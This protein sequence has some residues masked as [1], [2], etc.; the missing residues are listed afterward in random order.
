MLRLLRGKLRVVLALVLG[1]PA[2]ATAGD[3]A[4]FQSPC[5][6]L[7]GS[8]AWML[9]DFCTAGATGS[10]PAQ[11]PDCHHNDDDS[12]F[13]L[14][15]F[16]FSLFGSDFGGA[17]IN[18]NG[19][20]T[21]GQLSSAFTSNGFPFNGPL[22]VAPFWA[23]VDTGDQADAGGAHDRLGHVYYKVVDGHTLAVLWDNVGY[24]DERGDKLNT[25]Q[26]LISD[27]SNPEMG[28]GNNVCFCYDDMQWT[29]GQASGSTNGFG[30][31][32]ATVGINRG[33]G[34]DFFQI[35]RFN[36][37]GTS[38][39]GPFGATDGVDFLDN[40][41][42]GAGP[43]YCFNASGENVAPVPVGFPSGDTV[44]I[45]CKVPFSLSLDF[46]SPE[47][48]QTTTVVIDDPD[49]A[50]AA[51]LAISN[52]PGETAEVQL[53]WVPDPLDKGTYVLTFTATDDA[54]DPGETVRTLTIVVDCPNQ[55]PVAACTAV[56]VSADRDTCTAAASID[57]GSFDPDLDPITLDQDPPP[58]YPLGDTS[59]TLIVSD[60]E[61]EDSCSATVTVEDVT[62]PVISGVTPS[63]AVLWPPNHKMHAVTLAVDVT[64]ACGAT[65]TCEIVDVT[66]NEPLN[67]RG[68][69]NT[70]ADW[71]ITG[72]LTANLRAERA[73]PL[74]GRV[75]T[76]SLSCVDQAGNATPA[77]TTVVVPHDQRGGGPA[78]NESRGRGR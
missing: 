35:G 39:D 45:E 50:Q 15:P 65:P 63:P 33:N 5:Q 38:Y 59:V 21:F 67:D 57:D 75:Y 1:I 29:T 49:G 18:N 4:N 17:F 77:S 61:Y 76:F 3:P 22:M 19:N 60:G 69:G 52:T 54:N 13:L 16:T 73:G 27:G 14:L 10:G 11:P 55:P 6:A 43:G 68:D 78:A 51:G 34:V 12:A 47:P 40:I 25:F 72:P 42:A 23:D 48:G 74:T 20:V 32:P 64:D 44:E 58:P 36:K 53:D 41:G 9:V 37:P 30:G 70:S 71:E 31:T 66:S 7:P 28:A 8:G 56:T 46:L 62:P 26:V 24:Y 2:T